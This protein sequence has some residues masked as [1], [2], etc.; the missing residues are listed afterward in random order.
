MERT[1]FTCNSFIFYGSF[2]EA[3]REL[4]PEQQVEVYNAIFMFA[5]EGKETPLKGIPKAVFALIRPQL[6]A[7]RKRYLNGCKGGRKTNRIGTK[8]EPNPNQI[9]TETE[10][11]PNQGLEK[12]NNQ[13]GTKPEPNNYDYN[14]NSNFDC[15]SDFNFNYNLQD[16]LNI[17]K[18]FSSVL[19]SRHMG[20][21]NGDYRLGLIMDEIQQQ[22][23]LEKIRE[24]ISH[25]NQTY[26]VQP[27]YANLDFCWVLNNWQRVL[28]TE[29]QVAPQTGNQGGILD[30]AKRMAKKLE[31]TENGG[32][33]SLF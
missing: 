30:Q 28:A 13:S 29:K 11:K 32:N 16:I 9:G 12:E 23:P 20:D 4:T 26:I 18:E 19:Y 31:E 27:K 21:P 25:A 10:P 15:N 8:P 17:C 1:K 3:V 5:F 33:T 7:N 14:F 22:L 24:V 6:E 2:Y